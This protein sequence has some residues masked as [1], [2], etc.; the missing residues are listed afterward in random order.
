VKF[1]SYAKLNL[2]LRIIGKLKSG[3]HSINSLIVF[4]DLY[5]SVDIKKGQNSGIVFSGIFGHH[6]DPKKD[7]LVQSTVEALSSHLG[8]DCRKFKIEI[9]KNIP[10]ASGLGGGSINAATLVK[11]LLKVTGNDKIYDPTSGYFDKKKYRDLIKILT[12]LGTDIPVCFA[13]KNSLVT[14]I[15][16]IVNPIGK[17]P[18]FW[19]VLINPG[20]SLSTET[21]Y[22]NFI[23]CKERVENL[24]SKLSIN[25]LVNL[26]NFFSFINRKCY[27]ND[28]IPT[29][30]KQIPE[31]QEALKLL[32]SVKKCKKVG[33]S[34]SGATCYGLFSKENEAQRCVDY[35]E[36][37]VK[38]WW[39][40]KSKILT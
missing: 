22:N 15:G 4:C 8:V 35:I 39:V 12:N 7:Y 25:S 19:L 21:V 2:W 24:E 37:K 13:G 20:K 28:L 38:G 17:L 16:D 3:Y 18:K 5:D 14:G 33:M 30:I 23:F 34:G 26:E 10:I 29:A 6:L 36:K 11:G 31:I 27:T 9:E 32:S 40:K 1:K